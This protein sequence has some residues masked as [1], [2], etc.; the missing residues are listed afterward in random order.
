MLLTNLWRVYPDTKEEHMAKG[1]G[2]GKKSC[3]LCTNVA[4]KYCTWY[5]YVPSLRIENFFFC[6]KNLGEEGG[7]KSAINNQN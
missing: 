7:G 4:G 2:G 3:K 5:I 6:D 1:G